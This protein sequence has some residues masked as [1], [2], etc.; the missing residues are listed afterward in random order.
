[1]SSP[2]DPHEVRDT[3]SRDA[4]AAGAR[5]DTAGSDLEG[6]LGHWGERVGS[7]A[8]T[9]VSDLQRR[10]I[11]RAH[12]GHPGASDSP[13]SRAQ[14]AERLVDDFAS[15]ARRYGSVA[16]DQIRRVASR[17]REEMEDV[18]A[19]AR[20]APGRH[21][22]AAAPRQ[23]E[24]RSDTDTSRANRPA[25]ALEPEVTTGRGAET[26]RSGVAGAEGES[27]T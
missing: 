23:P 26:R 4:E 14:H 12:E 13:E 2:I 3:S 8:R 5:S 10:G 9:V 15:W 24:E 20:S 16:A 19:E 7:A 22:G 11:A 27:R 21:D 18:W 17:A 25:V 6:T 1:M